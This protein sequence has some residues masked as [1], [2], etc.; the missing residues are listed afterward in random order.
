MECLLRPASLWNVLEKYSSLAQFWQTQQS[1]RPVPAR[2]IEQVEDAHLVIAHSLCAVLRRRLYTQ[3]APQEVE[4]TV[5]NDM[6][7]GPAV[8]D[9]NS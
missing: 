6:A 8:A 5:L 7:V 9:L 4:H 3:A 1:Y 2:S